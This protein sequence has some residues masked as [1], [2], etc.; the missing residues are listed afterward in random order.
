MSVIM[1]PEIG[2]G[3]TCVTVG[4]AIPINSI[5]TTSTHGMIQKIKPEL[6]GATD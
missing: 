2:N 1:S 5:V 4:N 3:D 6:A